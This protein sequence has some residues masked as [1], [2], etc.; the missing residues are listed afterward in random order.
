[1]KANCS[2]VKDRR[3]DESGSSH[4]KKFKP[5]HPGPWGGR[6]EEGLCSG[7][8]N[9]RVLTLSFCA[10]IQLHS[11]IGQQSPQLRAVLLL[12]VEG[13]AKEELAAGQVRPGGQRGALHDQARS[14]RGTPSTRRSRAI[15]GRAPARPWEES[16]I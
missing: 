14:T 16:P 8:I 10:R 15:P 6:R 9:I 2:C 13:G 7:I 12:Q 4:K 11:A 5:S 1:M 3:P